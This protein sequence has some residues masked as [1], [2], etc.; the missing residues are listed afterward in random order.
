MQMAKDFWHPWQRC[1]S[2]LY[3]ETLFGPGSV[4]VSFLRRVGSATQRLRIFKHKLNTSRGNSGSIGTYAP[5]AFKIPSNPITISIERSAEIP[6]NTSESTHYVPL[7]RMLIDWHVGSI[8]GKSGTY[9]HE[10]NRDGVRR[11]LH[12]RFKRSGQ[13]SLR[14]IID[15]CIIPLH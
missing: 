5:P 6:T 9:R 3:Q 14:S 1:V 4:G 2:N 13:E 8:P 15:L 11:T 7:N 12:L 10:D